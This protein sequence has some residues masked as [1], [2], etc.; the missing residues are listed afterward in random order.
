MAGLGEAASIASFVSL[1]FQL[2]DGCIKGFVLL[3]AAQELGSR[4]DVLACQLEWEQYCLHRWAR[5][6]GL[7]ND[8]P[9]LNVSNP[10]LVQNTLAN[11]EQL[12]TNAAKLKAHYGLDV[13]LTEEEIREV[14]T[15]NRLFGFLL[16]KTKPQFI[17]DTAKVYARRNN[18]WKKVKWG[19]IDSDRLRLLLTSATSINDF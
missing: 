13:T 10:A 6:V 16:E 8:P 19:A 11:L 12:L 4:G 3:S 15:P 17:N 9:E 7:F 18:A 2:F 5:T 1:S 14:H